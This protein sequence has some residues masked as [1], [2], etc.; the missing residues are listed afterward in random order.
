MQKKFIYTMPFIQNVVLA[1]LLF[2][3]TI[4]LDPQDVVFILLSQKEPYHIAHADM[5]KKYI[6]EQAENMEKDLP[7]VLLTHELDITGA[8]TILPLLPHLYNNYSQKWYFFFLEN[9]AI[10]LPK[11][12]DVL[13][14]YNSNQDLWIG[15]ALYDQEPTIIHHFAENARKF[16]YPNIAS[17]FAITSKLLNKLAET[18]LNDRKPSD[19]FFIDASYE[20]ANFVFKY[21]NVRLRHVAEICI[22]SESKCAT[23]PKFFHPCGNTVPLKNVFFA[24]KTCSKYHSSRTKI[25][26]KTWAKYAHNIGYFTDKTDNS[27]R[28]TYIAPNTTRGHCVKTYNILE[29]VSIILENKV[30]DWIILS[31]DDTIFSVSRLLRMLTCYNPKTPV[32]IGE[33]YGYKLWDDY[34]GYDYL[35]GGAGL[36]LSAPLVKKILDEKACSCPSKDTPDDMF[37]FG[38]CLS[39]INI[40][41]I[42]CQ[43]LHQA[44]P[45]DY[46]T[47]FLAAHEPISFH[48]FWMVNPETIYNEW[49]AEED[50]S[51]YVNKRHTEL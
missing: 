43:M 30:I 37:L 20:F 15:H 46:A 25:V 5:M 38:I 45:M 19:D 23:Y 42:H 27:I 16:K 21:G 2:G 8:W 10:R 22:I 49:F 47:A 12:I 31:D 36:A 50:S 48:K 28:N 6:L 35:T 40:K 41:P 51:L 34:N 4:A 11:L 24:V 9:T 13:N 14:K 17:G 18:L 29:Q 26:E 39:L 44:R 33:R 1:F 32:A 3:S 7:T